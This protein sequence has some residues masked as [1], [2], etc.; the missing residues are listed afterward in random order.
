MKAT[1]TTNGQGL[2]SGKNTAEG[3]HNNNSSLINKT[4]VPNTP[5]VIVQAGDK[6]FV[7]MGK[8]RL[9]QPQT[10]K[11]CEEWLKEITWEKIMTFIHVMMEMEFEYK[12]AMIKELETK[13]ADYEKHGV[14]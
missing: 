14:E 6:H 3:T 4:E 5:Y 8:Y 10:L 11:E 13:I 1:T 7:V 9:T 2:E 12:N